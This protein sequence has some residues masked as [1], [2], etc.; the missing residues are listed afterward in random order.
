MMETLIEHI[1]KDEHN[2]ELRVI[3]LSGEG[4]AFSG[5]HNLKELASNKTQQEACF[6]SAY[7]LMNTLIDSPVPIIA[8]VDGIAAA[9][10]CQLVAQCDISICSDQSKFST[11]GANFGLFCSTPGVALARSINK[12]PALYMLFT[13]LPISA[14]EAKSFGLVSKVYSGDQLDDEV[15][16]ICETIKAKSR[17]VIELG[18][19]FYY[20]QVECDVRKAYQLGCEKMLENLQ[21]GDCREGIRSFIEKRKPQWGANN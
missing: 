6:T 5:G 9:A 3:V 12:M 10:G 19:R 15:G 13:G 1:K 17:D 16:V 21:I 7:K 14:E 8:K 11:P 18:K 2:P 20:K 4:P